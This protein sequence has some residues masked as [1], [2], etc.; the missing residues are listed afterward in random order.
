[1]ASTS[2]QE[3]PVHVG[4]FPIFDKILCRLGLRGKLLLALLP[5]IV[6]ILLATGYAS[7]TVT[8]EFIDIALERTVKLHTMAVTHEVEQY[9]E[10]CRKDLLFFSHA[11]MSADGLQALFEG[12]MAVGGRPYFELCFIP[13]SGGEPVALVRQGE[14][15]HRVTGADLS[16]VRPN[17]FSEL[18]RMG[19]M[20][21]GQVAV[22]DV[23]EVVY[24]VTTGT[25]SNLYKSRQVIR[26]ITRVPGSAT[27]PPGLLFLSFE[28][29]R[30]RNILSWYNSDKSPLWAFPRSDELRFSYYLNRDGWVLF[31]SEDYA[32]TEKELT[33]YLAREDFIGTLGKAGHGAAFRPNDK[34]LLYWQ[35]MENIRKGGNGLKK[36]AQKPG[37]SSEVDSFYFSYASVSFQSLPG[38]APRFWAGWSSW[39]A[40]SFR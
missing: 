37:G 16:R 17:P 14:A 36:I 22:S 28:A 21:E 39:T 30:L 29:V 38:K 23:L 35:M 20:I 7:Y 13:A 15:V 34:C 19:S 1:M 9:L 24:P 3:R 27:T 6:A 32:D 33:T 31:Q 4:R 10:E 25:A 40:V 11:D 18:N 8:E 12:R 26:M 2:K 5:P